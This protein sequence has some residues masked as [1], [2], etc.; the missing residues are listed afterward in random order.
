[1]R[2]I[3]AAI[4]PQTHDR[5][6]TRAA[7]L[8]HPLDLVPYAQLNPLLFNGSVLIRFPVAA[9]IAFVIAGK[10]GGSVGSPSPVG[11]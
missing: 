3:L 8:V 11:E 7:C 5:R 1:M 9:K 2:V 6:P 4:Y 10:T